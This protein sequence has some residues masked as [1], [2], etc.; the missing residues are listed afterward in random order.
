MLSTSLDT[1]LCLYHWSQ[2]DICFLSNQEWSI[3]VSHI[4]AHAHRSYPSFSYSKNR[5]RFHRSSSVNRYGCW[6][7]IPQ[8]TNTLELINLSFVISTLPSANVY[9]RPLPTAFTDF[10]LEGLCK[11]V[12]SQPGSSVYHHHKILSVKVMIEE[13]DDLKIGVC[14]GDHNSCTQGKEVS[15]LQSHSSTS[16]SSSC[17]VSRLRF[18]S[19]EFHRGGLPMHWRA[20]SRRLSS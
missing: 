11:T 2:L 9:I 14:K 19:L 17:V 15:Y 4:A 6:S 10:D 5:D 18:L 1:S 7:R 8:S 16:L 20:A 3:P 13:E 12:V